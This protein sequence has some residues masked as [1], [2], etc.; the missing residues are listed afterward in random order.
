MK[1]QPNVDTMNALNFLF[2][3]KTG[4]GRG[5]LSARPEEMKVWASVAHHER[6]ATPKPFVCEIGFALGFSALAILSQ[7]PT[8]TYVGFDKG[9]NG[10]TTGANE[11][12]SL[13]PDRFRIFWGDSSTQIRELAN[14]S[15]GIRCD[16]WIID[17]DHS[18]E[19]AQ[20]DLMAIIDTA[21]TLITKYPNNVVLWDDVPLDEDAVKKIPAEFVVDPQ[22]KGAGGG[23]VGKGPHCCTGS[24]AVLVEAIHNERVEFLEFGHEQ[25]RFNRR[26]SWAVTSLYTK[27]E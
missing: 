2:S 22:S 10:P 21:P 11:L 25:N 14:D 23:V 12:Q 17:G 19:G 7:H 26:T 15:K 6:I 1:F 3:K 9:G 4:N 13:Y 8:V 18:F 20:K 24:S 5:F 27:S 16:V